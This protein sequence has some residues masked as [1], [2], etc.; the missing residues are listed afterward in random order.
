MLREVS[1]KWFSV[2]TKLT[3]ACINAH[4]YGGLSNQELRMVGN[5][6]ELTETELFAIMELLSMKR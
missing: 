6:R 4:V 3:V 2:F 5:L 1:N